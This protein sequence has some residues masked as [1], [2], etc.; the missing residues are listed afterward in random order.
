MGKD[1]LPPIGARGSTMSLGIPLVVGL[2]TVLGVAAVGY[3]IRFYW[4]ATIE[5][6]ILSLER[7]LED[8]KGERDAAK[9]R[10]RALE[11]Q[12]AG[13]SAVPILPISA[14]LN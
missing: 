13:L 8:E 7:S 3:G 5:T 2:V 9:A 6:Q 4:G 1:F 14:F 10:I 12:V 11:T